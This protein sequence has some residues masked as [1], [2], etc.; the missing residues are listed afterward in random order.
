MPVYGIARIVRNARLVVRAPTALRYYS[1]PPSKDAPREPREK[2]PSPPDDNAIGPLVSSTAE[3]LL[4]QRFLHAQNKSAGSS[5]AI[6][7]S[8]L[9]SEM[10]KVFR[11]RNPDN[12]L[13]NTAAASQT[14]SSASS[15]TNSNTD[16]NNNSSTDGSSDSSADAPHGT[17][18]TPESAFSPEML[19]DTNFLPGLQFA[20]GN[21]MRTK[22]YHP[23]LYQ[24]PFDTYK[25]VKRLED[26]GWTNKKPNAERP[27]DPAETIM[28][29]TRA[30]LD[31][32]GSEVLRENMDKSD[33]DNQLY[34]FSAALS[35]LRTDVT[36]RA[37]NDVAALRSLAALLQR[38]VDG[39]EQKMQADV[40]RLKHDI[41]V[42]MN[43]RKNETKGDQ[44]NLEQ[45]IQD[46]NNRFTIFLSDLRTEIE[47]SIKWDATRRA[48][49]LVFGIVAILVCTLALADHLSQPEEE[50]PPRTPARTRTSQPERR[51]VRRPSVD[52]ESEE[53]VPPKSAE[54]WG[55]LPRYDTDEGRFV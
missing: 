22:R 10:P 46:L 38:E 50:E 52:A 9:P 5:L 23:S 18:P 48:L 41:Q 14:T 37:R 20:S 25:F 24:P 11:N 3:D 35:E 40:E 19:S 54:E 49:A 4:K 39:L 29:A 44:N 43:H 12:T 8:G 17:L 16:N 21:L 33:L 26:G 45:E 1:R 32:K 55:L 7:G 2:N 15:S 53:Y 36:V 30:L 42:E 28:E 13:D 27:H 6:G 47:Q 34:F 31:Q 51:P